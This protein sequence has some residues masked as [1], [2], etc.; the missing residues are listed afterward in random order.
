[1]QGSALFWPSS[2]PDRRKAA[3]TQR[4]P[5]QHAKVGWVFSNNSKKNNSKNNSRSSSSSTATNTNSKK[6][7]SLLC[8]SVCSGRAHMAVLKVSPPGLEAG[9]QRV[10]MRLLHFSVASPD[11]HSQSYLCARVVAGY[12]KY[13]HLRQPS[14]ALQ[15]TCQSSRPA[16]RSYACRRLLEFALLPA[17]NL[18]RTIP[19]GDLR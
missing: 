17:D 19:E 3:R 1:M 11:L 14:P 18:S 4:F 10:A 5:A 7:C 2:F 13:A 16:S 12:T 9:G 6:T 15:K 8:D